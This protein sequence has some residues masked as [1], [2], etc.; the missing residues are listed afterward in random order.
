MA[1]SG[2]GSIAVIGA[3]AT[4]ANN[5]NGAAG[6]VYVFTAGGGS[7]ATYPLPEPGASAI[8]A[9]GSA[10]AISADGG[11]AVVGAP[12][13]SNNLGKAYVFQL[14]SGMPTGGGMELDDPTAEAVQ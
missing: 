5:G 3:P 10:V 7:W 12:A 6:Q 11:L 4:A 1:L 14:S 13:F 2:D 9:Y 8:D